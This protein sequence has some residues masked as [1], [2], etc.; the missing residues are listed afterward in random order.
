MNKE[1]LENVNIDE[2]SADEIETNPIMDFVQAIEAEQYSSA[3]DIFADQINNRL[4]DRLDTKK[5][6]VA[7]SIFNPVAEE[8]LEIEEFE[9]VNDEEF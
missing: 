3:T 9:P 1:N 2:I 6:E 7:T 4:I 8:D 5:V